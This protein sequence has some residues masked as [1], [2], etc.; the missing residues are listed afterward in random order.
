M[1]LRRISAASGHKPFAIAA[2]LSSHSPAVPLP[3]VFMKR[4]V[5]DFATQ[6]PWQNVFFFWS[7]ERHVPPTDPESNYRMANETLLSK[8]PIP[9]GNIFPYPR[10]NARCG[11]SRTVL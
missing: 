7:D 1:P 2:A 8:L 9:A 4:L 3:A 6:L 5:R 10:G 11:R